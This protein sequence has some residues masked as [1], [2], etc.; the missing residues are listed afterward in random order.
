[1][2]GSNLSL[3][4][5][6]AVRG[7]RAAGRPEVSRLRL[8]SLVVVVTL[9]LAQAFYGCATNP[10]TGKSEF[11]V[12]S[13]K[14]E[15]AL[16]AQAYNGAI[17]EF[18][19]EYNDPELAAYVSGVG[20]SLAKVSHRPNLPYEFTVVGSSIMNAF[21]LP[22]GKI[23]ITTGLLSKFDNEAEVA[24]VL[25]HEIGHVTARHAA[26]MISRA[27][28]FQI[29]LIVGSIYADRKG[30]GEELVALSSVGLALLQLKYSRDQESQ[31]D[32]L[33]MEYA[34]KAGY[35][36]K[37]MVEVLEVLQSAHEKEP[38]ALEGMLMTHPLTS[39]RISDA[40]A[41]LAKDYPS[42]QSRTDM[43]FA[44]RFKSK[45]ERMM[46]HIGAFEHYDAAEGHY[47]KGEFDQALQEY[48]AAIEIDDT[49]PQFHCGVGEVYIKKE[50][51]PNALESFQRAKEL[52]PK[53]FRGRLD[54][55]YAQF[56]AERYEPAAG[57]LE[58][59]VEIVPTSPSAQYFLGRSYEK[60]G[61]RT[62]AIE[63]YE[64]AAALAPDTDLGKDAGQ[65]AAAL[66]AAG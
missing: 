51:T 10:V 27:Y 59:A 50:D 6:F 57:E 42:W 9:A 18:G 44:D 65:R 40:E 20:Q 49:Q 34:E 55:G 4:S 46:T 37:G 54:L 30:K 16:G 29:P 36:P 60:L 63:S 24:G 31:S 5:P 43:L 32:G 56:L 52:D 12:I 66:K 61:R 7:R 21:A 38:S 25:G 33:G 1:M 23:V 53:L 19:G 64:N 3:V 45:T 2:S 14:D 26:K 41:T 13:E 15:I 47:E 58:A 48:R 62:E 8:A 28:L 22:G 17:A 35:N 11:S 39:S